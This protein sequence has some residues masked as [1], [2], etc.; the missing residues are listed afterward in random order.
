MRDGLFIDVIMYWLSC[1]T[2]EVGN[3]PLIPF[4]TFS[5]CWN[6]RCFC[7]IGIMSK[8]FCQLVATDWFVL[9][10]KYVSVLAVIIPFPLRM[11]KQGTQKAKKER[12][13]VGYVYERCEFRKLDC[14]FF[15]LHH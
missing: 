6:G 13:T 3:C 4:V 12:E 10:N 1:W 5:Y 2:C 14:M 7:S 9:I 8:H 11:R 15:L